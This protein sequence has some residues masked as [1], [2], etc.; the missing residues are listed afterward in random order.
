MTERLRAR[1]ARL[2]GALL[3]ASAGLAYSLLS[4]A[5]RT[6]AG[7]PTTMAATTRPTLSVA[8]P[9][10]TYYDQSCSNCHGPHGSFYGPT[11]GNNL[12]DAALIRKCHE[13][14]KGPGNSPLE[15]DETLAVTAY[16]RSLISG[17]PFLSV[18][19]IA[20]GQWAGEATAGAKVMLRLNG[21]SIAA[22]LDDWNWTATLPADIDPAAVVIDATLNGKQTEL[23][24]AESA[25][26]NTT[27][28][29]PQ[30]QRMH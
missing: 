28:L 23:H 3:L 26:S 9:A 13:M 8:F 2:A 19:S 27:P 7:V 20:D 10:M 14:E 5:T 1:R 11:L 24:P 25:Y 6:A 17:V 18:T 12:S 16:H 30:G 4:S 29:P 22:T 21:R 15:A